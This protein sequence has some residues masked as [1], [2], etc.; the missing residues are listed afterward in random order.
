[1]EYTGGRIAKGIKNISKIESKSKT[2]SKSKSVTKSKSKSVT[3]SKGKSVTKSKGKSVTKSKSKIGNNVVKNVI[4]KYKKIYDEEKMLEND[5]KKM[6]GLKS[7]PKLK[8]FKALWII[9][10][11]GDVYE[12][13]RAMVLN[14][15]FKLGFYITFYKK[16]LNEDEIKEFIKDI[17]K[18]SMESNNKNLNNDFKE[19]K[20]KIYDDFE[21]ILIS[22]PD[23][24]N[25]DN[26]V[27]NYYDSYG[28]YKVLQ[29]NLNKMN[30]MSIKELNTY[31]LQNEYLPFEN[32]FYVKKGTNIYKGV[33]YFYSKKDELPFFET[34]KYGYYGDKYIALKYA[35]RYSGGL[36]VYKAK[37]DLKFFD[38]T[39]DDNIK[40]ILS[41]IDE[42]SNE[43]FFRDVTYKY[44]AHCVKMKYGINI[45]KYYQAY[46]ICLYFNYYPEQWLSKMEDKDYLPTTSVNG[47][48]YTGWYFGHG[49][50]DR[51]CVEGIMHLIKDKYDGATSYAGYYTPY[52]GITQNEVIIW[53]QNEN[54]ERIEKDELDSMLFKKTLPFDVSKMAFNEKMSSFNANFKFNLFY[55]NNYFNPKKKAFDI[56]K[57]LNN[58][59]HM[60]IISL[61]MHNFVSL[62]LKDNFENISKALL[63]MLKLYDV[64]FCFMEEYYLPDKIIDSNYNIIHDVSH[65]GLVVLYKKSLEVKNIYS[66]KLNNKKGFDDRRY[67]LFFEHNNKKYALTHLEIGKRFIGRDNTIVLPEEFLNIAEFNSNIRIAQL[68][69]V[70]KENPDIIIGDMNFNKYDKEFIFMLK[71]KYYTQFVDSTSVHGTQVDF[72]FSKN[73]YNFAKTIPYSFSDHLPIFAIL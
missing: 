2:K 65:L 21:K 39:N 67:A 25:K 43:K 13:N 64:D 33:K 29:E 19:I 28:P 32:S 36:Q 45:N 42:N 63:Q 48:R 26:K 40:Y 50:I 41:L 23:N 68:Q 35:K 57:E 4:L 70:L 61:N 58:K 60:K 22:T 14:L 30:E 16:Y 46:L 1:M 11:S 54:L 27:V 66:I 9:P 71:N 34:V 10:R 37:K 69:E 73:P 59:D 53:N 7:H 6:H 55:F 72:I 62:N 3:K 15:K 5:K 51:I 17:K 12:K 52:M 49:F 47:K 20:N 44:F 18:I 31:F 24:D 56:P 8:N 38:V